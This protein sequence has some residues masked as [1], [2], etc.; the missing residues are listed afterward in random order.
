MSSRLPAEAVVGGA[1][2]P[3][4]DERHE[5]PTLDT[6]K[7]T[8]RRDEIFFIASGYMKNFQQMT[9]RFFL[10]KFLFTTQG[11]LLPGS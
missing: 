3:A 5:N 2:S 10:W 6:V 7:P 11:C 8:E 1:Q 4:L 9:Y